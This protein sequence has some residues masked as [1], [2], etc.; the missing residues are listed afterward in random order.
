MQIKGGYE[1]LITKLCNDTNM[2]QKIQAALAEIDRA[3]QPRQAT[4]LDQGIDD[5]GNK[6]TKNSPN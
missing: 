6:S 4:S 1:E 5:T 2:R 3:R